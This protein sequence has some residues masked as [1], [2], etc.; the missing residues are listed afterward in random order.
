[1][2]IVKKYKYLLLRI[3]DVSRERRVGYGWYTYASQKVQAAFPNRLE[4]QP[5]MILC[6]NR[7][8]ILFWVNFPA[9]R[10]FFVSSF[11]FCPHETGSSPGTRAVP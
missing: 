1:M 4:K 8:K 11:S 7:I 10:Y 9:L 2:N 3:S 5:A 6:R